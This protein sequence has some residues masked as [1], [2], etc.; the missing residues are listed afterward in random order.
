MSPSIA[1]SS[2]AARTLT[3]GWLLA[4]S[5]MAQAGFLPFA[6]TVDGVS[7]ILDVIDPSGPVVRVQTLAFGS[8]SPGS[9]TYRSG[10][11]INLGNGQGSGTNSF[12]TA[13]G[14]ALFGSFTV[15]LVPGA[16]PSLFDL[17]GQVVFTGGTGDFLGA[18]GAATF[19]A[20][21]QFVSASEA[22]TRFVF[23]GQVA[24]VPEPGTAA[25]GLLGVLALALSRTRRAGAGWAAERGNLRGQVGP[26]PGPGRQVMP[27][28][29][30]RAP[31]RP[32]RG[33]PANMASVDASGTLDTWLNTTLSSPRSPKSFTKHRQRP[34]AADGGGRQVQHG[35]GPEGETG[36]CRSAWCHCR[37]RCGCGCPHSWPMTRRQCR[38]PAAPRPQ[39]ASGV[40]RTEPGTL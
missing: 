23:D 22:T 3:A 28:D 16:D 37:R 13:D 25:L 21:G 39:P 20:E 12:T 34:A 15:Q 35:V 33:R 2:A 38:S 11:T 7:Q 10:D 5:G 19:T 9:L 26:R 40:K 30:A 36:H 27:R 32:G 4:A 8:G 31:C 24:T 14:D 1:H 6:A 17:I 18:S 29:G